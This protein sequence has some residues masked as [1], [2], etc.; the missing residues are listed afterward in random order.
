MLHLGL[1]L[2]LPGWRLLCIRTW[3]NPNPEYINTYT[4]CRTWLA[5]ALYPNFNEYGLATLMV[6]TW[7]R[8][9]T[10]RG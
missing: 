9:A 1:G 3:V 4:N 6:S 10:S 5:F 2:P 7:L 8:T